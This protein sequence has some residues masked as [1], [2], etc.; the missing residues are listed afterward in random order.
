[1]S[2][3][4][5]LSAGHVPI[6]NQDAPGRNGIQFKGADE[7]GIRVYV[8]TGVIRGLEETWIVA[9]GGTV[10]LYTH[11]DVGMLKAV[12]RHKAKRARA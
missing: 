5:I 7:Y 3:I 8:R 12:Y 4:H 11:H 10:M 1:M 9:P 2:K 6:F